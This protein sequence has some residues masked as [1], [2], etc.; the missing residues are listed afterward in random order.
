M[1]CS[2]QYDGKKFAFTVNYMYTTTSKLYLQ[3]NSSDEIV[4]GTH[5]NLDAINSYSGEISYRVLD[6]IVIGLSAEYMKKTFLNR[7]MTLGGMR[8]EMNDGYKLIPV[9][10]TVYYTLPFSTDLFKFFMGGGGGLYFGE[11]IRKLGNVT[12][13]TETRKIGYGIHVTVGLDYIINKMLAVRGQMRFRDPEF[14]MKNKYSSTIVNY[15]DRTFL[16]S[17]DTFSSKVNI[18]GISFLLG[19]VFQF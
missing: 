11:H 4:R 18:D 19:V 7:N 12:S 9:E 14:E 6:E 2:A 15:G 10:M 1:N 16:L 3:P 8:I 17:S 13:T 5:E